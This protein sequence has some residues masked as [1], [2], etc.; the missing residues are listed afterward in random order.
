MKTVSFLTQLMYRIYY[1][2]QLDYQTKPKHISICYK[3]K[4]LRI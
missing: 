4:I 3:Q 1:Y 2:S